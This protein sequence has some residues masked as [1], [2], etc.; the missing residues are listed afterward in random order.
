MIGRKSKVSEEIKPREWE[1]AACGVPAGGRGVGR[2]KGAIKLNGGHVPALSRGRK[3]GGRVEEA[4]RNNVLY[5]LRLSATILT[6]AHGLGR[7]SDHVYICRMKYNKIS[8][9]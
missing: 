5:F 9:L 4:S 7:H 3:R 8:F 6:Q 2:R 1:K